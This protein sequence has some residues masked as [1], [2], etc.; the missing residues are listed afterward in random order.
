MLLVEAIEKVQVVVVVVALVVVLP[1]GEGDSTLEASTDAGD[2]VGVDVEGSHEGSG[3]IL[4]ELE[5]AVAQV[6][7]SWRRAH[8]WVTSTESLAQ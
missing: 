5:G 8:R 6:V 2:G 3:K 1:G 7:G 4:G